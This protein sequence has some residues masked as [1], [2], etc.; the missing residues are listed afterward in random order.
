MP[1]TLTDEEA[2]R[3]L[4]HLPGWSR[5]G[6][7]IVASIAAPDLP[8]AIRIVAAA[9]D[10]AERMSRRPD[11]D[12]RRRATHRLLTT[13]DA[14]DLTQLDIE[15]AQSRT[16]GLRPAHARLLDESSAC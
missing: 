12:L 11:I 4:R 16:G 6:E 3:R 13:P 14:G 2:A 8:A 1:H 15:L 10:L 9:A 5:A 7:A